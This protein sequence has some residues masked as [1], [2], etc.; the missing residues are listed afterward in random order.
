MK[1]LLDSHSKQIESKKPNHFILQSML[2]IWFWDLCQFQNLISFC[3]YGIIKIIKMSC[4]TVIFLT[5]MI[6][7]RDQYL[8]SLFY[9]R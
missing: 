1:S 9:D 8:Y 6:N 5:I 7:L 3:A 4:N 2:L